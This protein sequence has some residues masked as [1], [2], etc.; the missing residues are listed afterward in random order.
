MDT[1]VNNIISSKISNVL[2]KKCSNLKKVMDALWD[3]SYILFECDGKYVI[4][5]K[6]LNMFLLMPSRLKKE[7]EIDFVEPFPVEGI[8]WTVPDDVLFSEQKFPFKSIAE[9]LKKY[10]F[11]ND[12][13][14]DGERCF[15]TSAYS[16]YKV[17]GNENPVYSRDFY[18][19][20]YIWPVFKPNGQME[21]VLDI[22]EFAVAHG[23]KVLA[24]EVECYR[25][26]LDTLQ[27]DGLICINAC[28]ALMAKPEIER[29]RG[30]GSANNLTDACR[31]MLMKDLLDCDK[32]RADIEPYDE[33]LLTDPNRGHWDLWG[34]DENLGFVARDPRKDIREN[35]VVGIDFGT[36]ST[37]VV[38][39]SDDE[40]VMPMRVGTGELKKSLSREQYEN[41]TVMELVSFDN[42]IKAYK[43]G[44]R[45][46]THWDDLKISHQANRDFAGSAANNRYGSFFTNLKQWAG[47]ESKK[48][49]YILCDQEDKKVELHPYDTLNEDDFDPIEIYAYYL[50]LYINNMRNG[51]FLNY[52]LSFPVTYERTVQKRIVKSFEKG[53]KKSL[54][55]AVVED[56]QLMQR[57][58]VDGSISEP[59][60]YAVCA[61]QEYGFVPDENKKTYYGIFDF[62]GGTTDFDFG[63]WSVSEKR[64][65]DFKIVHFG[66]QGDKF[67]GGENLLELLA[68]N[69]FKKKENAELLLQK[70]ITFTLPQNCKEFAGS[71]ML[72]SDSSEAVYNTKSLMEKLR[73]IWENSES[74][75][76]K[77]DLEESGEIKVNLLHSDGTEEAAVGLKVSHEELYAILREKIDS[78]IKQFF[79]A[80]EVAFY[81]RQDKDM[82]MEKVYIL[83]AGNSSKS[84]LLKELFEQH[85]QNY[86]K[87]HQQENLFE[88]LPPIGS[89]DFVV[90]KQKLQLNVDVETN[91]LSEYE[92]PTGKTG[93]AFGLI[94]SRKG[95]R[96]E[97]ENKN[98]LGDEIPF[99]FYL[100]YMSRRRFQIIDEVD[101]P[102]M[103][104][105]GKIDIGPWYNFIE[106]ED[107]DDVVEVYFTSR[108]EAIENRMDISLTQKVRCFFPRVESDGVFYVRAKDPHTIEYTIGTNGKP[109][110][111]VLGSISLEV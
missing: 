90:A 43:E 75:E 93:V 106:V 101:N 11:K 55:S 80:F 19:D 24:I 31:I 59:A 7:N 47:T 9:F 105:K 77:K 48:N 14:L 56:E 49:V 39:Q 36:K 44:S 45:P 18:N 109:G 16:R 99:K 108:P 6:E 74:E 69:V 98:V 5:S 25:G 35:G 110:D 57:F 23:F 42:F 12:S 92:K 96:I 13:V 88:L 60:A 102:P 4:Y 97:V 20:A 34:K 86:E 87:E 107:G 38:Y 10:G 104:N 37:V 72:I 81:N 54:P 30:D 41:P 84:H 52:Y 2:T 94:M 78:G 64:K 73:P 100:G 26:C 76:S 111:K 79:T 70:D 17:V 32:I 21:N 71:E 83:L 65:F 103:Q 85:I 28:D 40:R 51:I 66:A 8:E 15:W 22:I 67:L 95:G 53:L 46:Q 62:G 33:K 29:L 3:Q 58:C 1:I 61:L 50:G 91:T 68:F 89:E 27:K 82:N 63:E